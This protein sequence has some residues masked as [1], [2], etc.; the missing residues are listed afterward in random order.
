MYQQIE[1]LKAQLSILLEQQKELNAVVSELYMKNQTNTPEYWE[2][3]AKGWKTYLTRKK[4]QLKL[5][6]LRQK[7]WYWE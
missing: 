6:Q 3:S 1:D 2:L 4:V 5:N 7:Y